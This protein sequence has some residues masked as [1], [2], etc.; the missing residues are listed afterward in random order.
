LS[1]ICDTALYFARS[2][3]KPFEVTIEHLRFK[4]AGSDEFEE[5]GGGVESIEGIIS[6]RRPHATSWLDRVNNKAPF[7]EWELALP[8]T[9]E[10]KNRFKEQEIEDILFVITYAGRTPAW[11]E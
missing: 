2:V 10:M 11:P 9:E 3:N 4:P 8:N 1:K 6:T 5:V 7:G